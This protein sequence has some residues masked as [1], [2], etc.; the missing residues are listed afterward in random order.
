MGLRTLPGDDRMTEG[1][2][3]ADTL[4]GPALV[5]NERE[6]HDAWDLGQ[7]ED[8]AGLEE[9][10]PST[11]RVVQGV[12]CCIEYKKGEFRKPGEANSYDDSP[13]YMMYADYGY[14][15]G[16]ISTEDGEERDVF[17]GLNEDSVKVYVAQLRNPDDPQTLMEEK[18]LLG[19]DDF[20]DA[21]KFIRDQY[22]FDMVEGVYEISLQDLKDQVE[23][24]KTKSAA[25]S[26]KNEERALDFSKR[27]MEDGRL[28]TISG[29]TGQH[30][31][32]FVNLTLN[33]L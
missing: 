29:A 1:A 11:M 22:Y 12:T 33:Q 21:Q 17:V 13:G 31:E 5:M 27:E 15:P 3:N 24:E 9:Q 18:V 10:E 20:E 4:Y 25:L 8:E 16:T 2:Q 28:A 32:P 6:T 14:L 19:F 7:R 23:M 26:R 30:T